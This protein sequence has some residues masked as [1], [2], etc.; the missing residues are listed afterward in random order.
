[1]GS[2]PVTCVAAQDGQPLPIPSQGGQVPGDAVRVGR[3]D[4][5]AVD[6]GP[7]DLA[8]RAVNTGQRWQAERHCL[9]VDDAEAFV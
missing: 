3:L 2:E 7:D 8:A 1:M 9:Q 4:Q 6:V 5:K